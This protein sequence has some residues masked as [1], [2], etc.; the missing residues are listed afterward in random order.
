METIATLKSDLA[1]KLHGVSLSKVES[2]YNTIAEAGRNLLQRLD[3][4]E[5]IRTEAIENA[6]FDN[7][8][9]YTAPS[10]LKG[11]KIIDLSPTDGRVRG[12]NYTK[13]LIEEFER[14]KS[15]KSFTVRYKNGVKFLKLNEDVR[16]NTLTISECNSTTGW[17]ASN[18]ATNLT[19][20]QVSSLTGSASLNFDINDSSSVAVIEN[21][22][23]SKVD[24]STFESEYAVFVWLYI[25]D[26]SLVTNQI[27]LI[28][29]D[30]SN[31][32]SKTVTSAHAHGYTDGWNLLRFDLK[33]ASETGTVDWSTIDFFRLTITHDRT[34]DTD[35]RLDSILAGVGEAYEATYYGDALFR[36]VDG[37]W[38]TIPTADTDIVQLEVDAYNIL[39]YECAYVLAQELQGENGQ[40]DETYFRRQ[41]DG[42][43]SNLGM[44][45][46]YHMSYPSQNKKARSSYYSLTRGTYGS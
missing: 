18:S 19:L 41:L 46:M 20:D 13:V 9:L 14:N 27:L 40:F 8:Y 16:T 7:I 23:L 22:T 12:D 32:V 25:P 31:Y 43:G 11:D 24:L 10:N 6:L 5:T 21:S 29:S 1:R 35:F 15:R 28:G 42:D 4:Q 36:G 34:G 44:Y 45:R 33:D 2:P 38:K 30:S 39:L 26:A 3:P 37:S 17:A